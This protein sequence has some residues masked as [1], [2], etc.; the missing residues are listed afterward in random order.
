VQPAVAYRLPC[1]LG[2]PPIALHHVGAADQDL[3]DLA[4]GKLAAR[5]VDHL[6]LRALDRDPYRA[7]L[8]LPVGAVLAGDRRG[9]REPVP[10][11]DLAAECLLEAA[12]QL[13]GERL[14]SRDAGAQ[15]AEVIVR[16]I[17]VVE[18]RRVHRR[19]PEKHSDAQRLNRLQRLAGV[20]GG[21]QREAGTAA[22]RGVHRSGLAEG[23]KEG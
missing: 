20:E 17:G 1:F 9:L 12:Q 6:H 18:H 22:K 21:K 14:A 11:E 5:I 19:H 2:P 4:V 7:R 13:D 10:L 8:S 23:V 16:A 15:R 3:P